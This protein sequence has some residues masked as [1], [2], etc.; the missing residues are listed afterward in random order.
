VTLSGMGGK[1]MAAAGVPLRVDS[2]E[3]GVMG[4]FEVS[5]LLVTFVRIFFKLV[6][7]AKEERPDAVVLIDYPGFNLRFAK[8][9]YRAG[10]PVIWYVCPQ[11]WVWAKWRLP[12]LAK[13]CTKML[14]IFPFEPEVFAST[15]LRATFVGHPLADIVTARKDP[16]IVRDP[17]T[18]LL[19]PGS[20][21]MEIDKLLGP[22]LESV[23]ILHDR[24]K[25]LSFHLAAPREK[26]AGR[27]REKISRFRKKYPDC[28][29]IAV[30]CGD[31]G[32]W[33]LRAGTGIAASGTVTVE[34][35][36]SGLPLVV[37]YKLNPLT[38]LLAGLLVRLYRGFFTMAN[39]I[40]NR[41]LFRELLQ[42]RFC[43]KNIVPA[44]EAILPGGPRRQEVEEGMA[45]VARLLKGDPSKSAARR[46]AEEILPVKR[47]QTTLAEK[48]IISAVADGGER[49][50]FAAGKP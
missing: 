49:Q 30:S 10:I 17:N 50:E 6:R 40:A 3:L 27:C 36:L 48:E 15:P 26:I 23:R 44:V 38:L 45:E 20:R 19:L 4:I 42:W 29:E 39:I 22:M 21:K 31:T 5:R 24:H 11:V 34:C 47:N 33:M 37:G 16:A 32:T 8:A 12:V 18:L 14:A 7:E 9:M 25:D 28:P 1:A 35:S 46:A 2:T 13:V 41:E 43:A